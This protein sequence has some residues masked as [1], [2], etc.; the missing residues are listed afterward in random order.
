[1]KSF[2]AAFVAGNLSVSPLVYTKLPQQ[3]KIPASNSTY[4]EMLSFLVFS[5]AARRIDFTVLVWLP[6]H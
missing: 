3:R 1:L 4:E 2:T 5:T 6:N